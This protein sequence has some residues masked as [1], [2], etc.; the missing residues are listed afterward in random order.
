M[1]QLVCQD[2]DFIFHS[3]HFTLFSLSP[4]NTVAGSDYVLP[5]PS[6]VLTFTAGSSVTDNVRMTS[7]ECFTV[8]IIND[9]ED[10]DD[11]SFV[12]GLSNPTGLIVVDANR[13]ASEARIAINDDDISEFA[14]INSYIVLYVQ[15][16]SKLHVIMS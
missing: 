16:M 12:C 11:E 4:T 7:V 1:T 14:C 5:D 3:F 15:I 13:D 9:N 10:D 8:S 2:C 6:I